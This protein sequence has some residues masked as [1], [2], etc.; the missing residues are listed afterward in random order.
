MH[1]ASLVSVSIHVTYIDHLPKY[2]SSESIARLYAVDCVPY[3]HIKTEENTHALKK[4]LN[5]LQ[6][7]SD[8]LAHGISL[9][10]ISDNEYYEETKVYHPTLCHP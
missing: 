4:P 5:D 8:R 6:R 2:I 9:P 1:R 7:W 3:R 10:E